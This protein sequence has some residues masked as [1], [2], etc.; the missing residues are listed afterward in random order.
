MKK[1]LTILV[2]IAG[3]INFSC[4]KELNLA[5]VSQISNASFWKSESDAQGAMNGM[6]TILRNEAVNNLFLWGEGRSDAMGQNAGAA[7]FQNWYENLLTADNSG[8]IFSGSPT[9]WAGMYNLIHHANLLLKYV[10]GISFGSEAKKN[11]ILAHAHAMRA[12]A[13]FTMSKT[14]GALPLVTEPTSDLSNIQRE[15]S[16]VGDVFSKIKSD[17]SE[18]ESLFADMNFQD[19][20]DMWSLPSL[21]A[22]KADVYLWTGKRMNG[23]DADFNTALTALN[24]IGDADLQLLPSF[25]DI[26]NYTNKNNKEILMAVTFKYEETTASTIYS[27]MYASDVFMPAGVDQATLDYIRPYAGVPFWGPSEIARNK[28]DADDKRK[29]ETL[30]E[31]YGNDGSGPVFHSSIVTKFNG[32]IVSGQRYFLDNFILYRYADVILMKAEAKNALNQNPSSEINQVRQRAYGDQFS[33]HEFTSS[34]KDANDAE[35]LDERFRELMFE[36]KRWWDLVRFGK[37]FDL[38]PSLNG[39]EGDGHLLLFPIPTSTLSLEPL[40]SQNTG[41]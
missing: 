7:V 25:G 17:I 1:H 29:K 15:R 2:F 3:M 12:F 19:G 27:W 22:L 37:A 11:N 30:T 23:G 38:V 21:L 36:G 10:P 33:G 20:R 39:R 16:S 9:T 14:W 40:V 35:I 31:I 34:T 6:Y 32:T 5:P 26:F 8:A 41:Y 18:A 28:F 13:Y 24:R 4:K